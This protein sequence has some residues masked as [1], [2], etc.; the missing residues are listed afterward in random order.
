MSLSIAITVE[1]TNI[2]TRSIACFCILS[3]LHC[4]VRRDFIDCDKGVRLKDGRK[5][6]KFN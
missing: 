3:G 2:M 1:G 6:I 4:N 5:M